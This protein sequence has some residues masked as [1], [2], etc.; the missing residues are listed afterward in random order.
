MF[1]IQLGQVCDVWWLGALCII[2]SL[3]CVWLEHKPR[4]LWPLLLLSACIGLTVGQLAWHPVLPPEGTYTVS[5]IV[6]DEVTQRDTKQI[7]TM[8]S[9]VTLDSQPIRGSA[10]WSFY[11]E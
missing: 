3:L 4:M 2:L 1:G 11:A 5:G 10:Y 8:L 7:H 9:N 6:I